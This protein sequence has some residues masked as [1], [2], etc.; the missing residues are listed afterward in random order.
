MSYLTNESKV[1]GT[2]FNVPEDKRR[3][4]GP[5][6]EGDFQ[7][8]GEAGKVRAAAW[9]KTTDDGRIYLSLQ[10]EMGRD[11]KYYG[12]LF[13]AND[14]SS[15]KAPDFFGSLNLGKEPGS[16][17]LRMAGWKRKGKDAPYRPFISIVIEPQQ[18]PSEDDRSTTQQRPKAREMADFPL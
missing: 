17:V 9:S 11:F 8:T 2:L 14:K 4:N 6:M 18:R 7:I 10:L 15:S 5:V 3:T 16:P 1:E 12:A 13:R